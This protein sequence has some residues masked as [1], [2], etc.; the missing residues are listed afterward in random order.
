[1][2]VALLLGLLGVNEV[3][4]NVSAVLNVVL[5]VLLA[6]GAVSLLLS[7]FEESKRTQEARR[8]ADT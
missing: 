5:L 1:M 2:V 3:P 8:T 7:L 4:R 6:F